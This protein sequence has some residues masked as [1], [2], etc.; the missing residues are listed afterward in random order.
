LQ[1]EVVF[2]CLGN[3]FGGY[4]VLERSLGI[5]T[6]QAVAGLVKTASRHGMV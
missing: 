5:A 4:A 1:A 3:R 6:F 2:C